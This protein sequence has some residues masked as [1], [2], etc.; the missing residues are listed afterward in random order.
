MTS[1][2]LKSFLFAI[3]LI[4]SA[5]L[6]NAQINIVQGDLPSVNDTLRFSFASPEQALS[7]QETGADFYWDY[8]HLEHTSQGLESYI[9][10][11]QINSLL[12]IVFG[13]NAYARSISEV[14]DIDFDVM[15]GFDN[16]Y[17]IFNKSSSVFSF[18]GYVLV[19][20]SFPIPMTFSDK[21]EIFLLPFTYEKRDSTTFFGS[22]ASGDTLYYETSGYRINEGDGWGNIITPYGEFECLRVKTKIFQRDSLFYEAIGEPVVVENTTFEYKWF[23][24]NKKLP[25]LEVSASLLEDGETEVPFMVRYRDIFRPY[26]EPPVA[27]FAVENAEVVTNELVYFENLSTPDHNYNEYTWEFS[28]NTVIFHEETDLNSIHPVVSFTSPGNYDVKLT[29][30]NDSGNDEITK[31]AFINATVD[32][33]EITSNETI[34]IYPNPAFNTISIQSSAQLK[35]FS[36]KTLDGKIIRKETVDV[37]YIDISNLTPGVY[38]LNCTDINNNSFK[39]VFIKQ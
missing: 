2:K 7:F 32:I 9:G 20:E 3:A 27:D 6:A 16:I 29:V 23:A 21:D 5:T 30:V 11:S 4:F 8:S 15:Q 19:Y 1:Q 35:E 36:I 14:F 26:I 39:S 37:N 38:I 12:G 17:Q 34:V 13:F 22:L 10:I 25:V 18:D 33:F 28:P 24:K 31:S